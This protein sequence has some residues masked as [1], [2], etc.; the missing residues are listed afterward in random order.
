M[1]ILGF[2]L[3][4]EGIIQAFCGMEHGDQPGTVRDENNLSLL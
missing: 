3:S 2:S 1:L 4:L